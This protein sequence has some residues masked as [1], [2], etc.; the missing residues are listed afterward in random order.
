MITGHKRSTDQHLTFRN[1]AKMLFSAN[2]LPRSQ[3]DTYAFYVRWI[4]IEFLNRF[5]L[6]DGTA[7]PDLDSKLQTPEELSGLLNIALEGLK[8]AQ[9]EWMEV[10][11]HQDRRRR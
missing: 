2:V 9:G 5:V 1:K 6:D 3:D 7:D 4:L 11:L 8:T 10:Q